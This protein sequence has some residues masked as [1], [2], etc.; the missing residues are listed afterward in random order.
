M[1]QAYKGWNKKTE[2]HLLLA[3]FNAVTQTGRAFSLAGRR[4]RKA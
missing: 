3:S 2:C 1:V 4:A